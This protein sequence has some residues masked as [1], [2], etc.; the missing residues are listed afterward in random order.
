MKRNVT[1]FD[2]FGVKLDV[3]VQPEGKIFLF[4]LKTQAAKDWVAEHVNGEA[5]FWGDALVVED[6]YVGVIAAAMVNDGGLLV[7]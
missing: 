2:E 5:Q 4:H 7:Q 1:G 3:S 6:R